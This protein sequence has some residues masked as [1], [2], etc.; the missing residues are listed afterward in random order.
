[1]YYVIPASAAVLSTFDIR[2]AEAK[3]R[4]VPDGL[5]VQAIL[6]YEGPRASPSCDE[7]APCQPKSRERGRAGRC[8]SCESA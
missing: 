2:E 1:M 6:P 4:S 3:L 5:I 7:Q 8:S